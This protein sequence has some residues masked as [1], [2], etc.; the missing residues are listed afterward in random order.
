MLTSRPLS[1][2][3]G[4]AAL[5]NAIPLVDFGTG[6]SGTGPLASREDHVHPASGPAP[7]SALIRSDTLVAG[8]FSVNQAVAQ[9]APGVDTATAT[10]PSYRLCMGFIQALP[11]GSAVEVQY[12]GPLGGFVGLTVGAT[13]YLDLTAGAIVS[14]VGAFPVGSIVQ[15]IGYAISATVLMVQVDRDFTVV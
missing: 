4:G 2:G 12:A 8:V 5:S 15:R 1:A 11:G 7:A 9:T 13:Y 10:G 6:A 14:S 3:G